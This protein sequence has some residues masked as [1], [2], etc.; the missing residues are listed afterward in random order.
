MNSQQVKDD[1]GI[2]LRCARLRYT[3]EMVPRFSTP[4]GLA[5]YHV[6]WSV[7]HSRATT[8][9]CIYSSFVSPLCTCIEQQGH[10]FFSYRLHSTLF[11]VSLAAR[12]STCAL[13]IHHQ[14]VSRPVPFL[15]SNEHPFSI[16]NLPPRNPQHQPFLEFSS[17]HRRIHKTGH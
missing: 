13:P 3:D 12:I 14:T 8:T 11:P 5:S 6:G 15:I 9:S 1:G 16:S 17:L 2:P 4:R 7:K 10:C